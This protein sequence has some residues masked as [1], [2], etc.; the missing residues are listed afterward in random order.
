M[1]IFFRSLEWSKT[2]TYTNDTQYRLFVLRTFSVFR[3]TSLA[4]WSYVLFLGTLGLLASIES[5]GGATFTIFQ[6]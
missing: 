6:S 1:L 2:H 4:S 3:C 5:S